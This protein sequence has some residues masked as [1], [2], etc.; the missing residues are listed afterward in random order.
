MKT[1]QVISGEKRMVS[2]NLDRELYLKVKV[3]A[4]E[5][6]TTITAILEHLLKQHLDH[7]KHAEIRT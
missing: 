4:A 6:D 1:R 2:L 3:F 7:C 5:R